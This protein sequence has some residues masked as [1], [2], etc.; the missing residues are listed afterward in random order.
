MPV[1]IS[2]KHTDVNVSKFSGYNLHITICCGRFK[3]SANITIHA[4]HDLDWLVQFDSN[5]QYNNRALDAS[6][7]FPK[8][9]I[10]NISKRL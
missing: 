4:L 8:Y 2:L 6:I 1:E 7:S 5:M 3:A 10:I 9:I